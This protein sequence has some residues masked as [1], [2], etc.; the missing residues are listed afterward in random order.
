MRSLTEQIAELIA[1]WASEHPDET[2]A[3]R[4]SIQMRDMG[5]V[6]TAVSVRRLCDTFD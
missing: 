2:T 1:V 5:F 4:L 3:D 6:S